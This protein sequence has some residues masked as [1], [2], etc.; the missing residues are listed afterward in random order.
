MKLNAYDQRQHTGLILF[1]EALALETKLIQTKDR[2]PFA[3]TKSK[4]YVI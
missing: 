4:T 3:Q 1:G 2:E